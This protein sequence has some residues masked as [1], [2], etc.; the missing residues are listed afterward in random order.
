MGRCAPVGDNNLF[1]LPEDAKVS[2]DSLPVPV[3]H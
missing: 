1:V 3:I 2:Y